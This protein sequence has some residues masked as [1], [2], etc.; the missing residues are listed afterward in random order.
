MLASS[1]SKEDYGKACESEE[2]KS[3]VRAIFEVTVSAGEPK[4]LLCLHH[5]EALLAGAG[6]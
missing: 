1:L 2:H 3:P 6:S 4:K 5:Y